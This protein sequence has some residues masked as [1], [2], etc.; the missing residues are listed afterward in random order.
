MLNNM[1]NVGGKSY[2]VLSF[3]FMFSVIMIFLMHG[4]SGWSWLLVAVIL[5]ETMVLMIDTSQIAMKY[6]DPTCMEP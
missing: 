2:T 6:M 5:I 1:K 4:I 3:I